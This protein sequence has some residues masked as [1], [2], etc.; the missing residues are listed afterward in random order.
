MDRSACALKIETAL[1][2]L[3]GLAD[4]NIDYATETLSQQVDKNRTSLAMVEGK[5]RSLA[6]FTRTGSSLNV[7]Q[8][9]ASNHR[10][11]VEE[12]VHAVLPELSAIEPS[13]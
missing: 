6:P 8:S 12:L 11:P 4:I 2:R 9:C 10:A 5:I 3:P 13:Q 7:L 1:K